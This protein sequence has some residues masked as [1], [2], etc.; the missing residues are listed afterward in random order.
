[1]SMLEKMRT[2]L[3]AYPD[4]DVRALLHADHLRIRELAKE[5]AESDSAPRRRS[6]VRELKPLLV[7]HSRS[8]EAAV[9]VPLMGLRSSPDSR[10]AGNEGMVEHNLADIVLTR[11]ANTSDATSD[12]WK[13]HAKVLHESLEHHIKEEESDLFEE[14][15]EH[16]T[17]AEREIMAVHFQRGKD[18][19]LQPAPVKSKPSRARSAVVE[20]A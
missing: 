4:T 6:L 20:T 8:E 19:L 10:L 7:A 5:L 17:D 1:M 11:L 16:F 14:L 15:G 9:Y 3:G 13:A 12:M 2:T 18:K